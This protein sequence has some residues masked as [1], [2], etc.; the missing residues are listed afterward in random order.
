M[1]TFGT[2]EAAPQN[3]FATALMAT[4]PWWREPF[5]AQAQRRGVAALVA[6]RSE[7]TNSL[8]AYG[9]AATPLIQPE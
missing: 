3:P 8:E 5:E 1:V 7:P 2:V 9:F 4:P 6:F